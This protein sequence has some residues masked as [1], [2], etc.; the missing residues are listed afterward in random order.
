MI[1]MYPGDLELNTEKAKAYQDLF[2]DD[3][4]YWLSDED[5][6]RPI[7]EVA[8]E[9]AAGQNLRDP[10]KGQHAPL[11]YIKDRERKEIEDLP[12]QLKAAG[13]YGPFMAVSTP[14][15]SGW[16]LETLLAEL[17]R[18]EA[19]FSK[20]RKLEE[21]IAQADRERMKTEP[22]YAEAVGTCW[23][24]LQQPEFPEKLLDMAIAM[25]EAANQ[26]I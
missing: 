25:L 9:K 6:G 17:D 26:D 18:E 16:N 12:D 23:N 13:L 21:L 4:F 2:K 22:K 19:Y 10:E 5:F 15:N 24:M 14:L 11:I 1:L 8:A 7:R 20:R 3:D